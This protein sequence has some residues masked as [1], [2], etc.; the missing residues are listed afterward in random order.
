MSQRTLPDYYR[1]VYELVHAPPDIVALEQVVARTNYKG[2]DASEFVK[3]LAE[4]VTAERPVDARA[5][6]LYIGSQVFPDQNQRTTGWQKMMHH[7]FVITDAPP[8]TGMSEEE[9][10]MVRPEI[11][12]KIVILRALE[13]GRPVIVPFMVKVAWNGTR[14]GD[15]FHGLVTPPVPHAERVAEFAAILKMPLPEVLPPDPPLTNGLPTYMVRLGYFR[16]F[17]HELIPV[18]LP[19]PENN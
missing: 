15:E 4:S 6:G 1:L 13:K 14:I 16:A 5:F 10:I 9:S 18:T 3:F 17:F 19:R 2:V 8:P 12:L 7:A 11:A